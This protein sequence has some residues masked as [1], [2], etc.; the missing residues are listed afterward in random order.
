MNERAFAGAVIDRRHALGHGRH[1]Y[2]GGHDYNTEQSILTVV[3]AAP[4]PPPGL[5]LPFHLAA[6]LAIAFEEACKQKDASRDNCSNLEEKPRGD[7]VKGC[8]YP[9]LSGILPRSV[10]TT[11]HD[12]RAH[13]GPC[14]RSGHRRDPCP[15]ASYEAVQGAHDCCAV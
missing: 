10:S 15:A 12:N 4:E 6:W 3:L 5:L 7:A 13:K 11:A 8:E 14:T 2:S 1:G 9:S